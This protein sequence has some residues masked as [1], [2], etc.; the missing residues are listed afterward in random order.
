MAPRKSGKLKPNRDRDAQNPLYREAEERVLAWLL[1]R[2]KEVTDV[3]DAKSYYDF[4][5]GGA[6]TLD[7][8]ADTVAHHTGR[9]VWEAGVLVKSKAGPEAVQEGWGQ[10]HGLSYIAYVLIPQTREE[11]G[12]P[13]LVVQAQ[14]LREA[15]SQAVGEGLV[16]VEAPLKPFVIEGED[17]DAWGY[18]ISMTWLR[19]KGLVLE[20]GEV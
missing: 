14:G 3:R 12:W 1:G 16:G 9:L 7:V 2:G 8:K 19:S 11:A 10:H 13:V 15:V 6:W 4:V 18:A 5:V 20:E 17:R